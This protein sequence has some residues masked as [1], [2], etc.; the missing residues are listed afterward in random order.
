M[1]MAP[2]ANH[3][4]RFR[5]YDKEPMLFWF[6]RLV[7]VGSTFLAAAIALAV[8]LVTD[9]LFDQSWAAL[10]AALVAAWIVLVWYVTPLW[11]RGG[12]R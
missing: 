1:L 11:Q 10:L 12:R 8:F 4:L 7:L 5:E 9:L 3:R 6:N 2:S